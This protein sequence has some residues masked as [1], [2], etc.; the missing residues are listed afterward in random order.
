MET[1][2][3]AVIAIDNGLERF[4]NWWEWEAFW[5][6]VLIALGGE[7]LLLL[8]SA[9]IIHW[10]AGWANLDWAIVRH[11]WWKAHLWT[12]AI[13]AAVTA[14]VVGWMTLVEWAKKPNRVA[15]ALR[16]KQP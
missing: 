1:I 11:A 5:S 9:V 16:G 2:A 13:L 4:V 15:E 3:L 10:Q 14:L 7:A 12:L 6:I 8:I